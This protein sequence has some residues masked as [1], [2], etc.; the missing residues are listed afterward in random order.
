[1]KT[2]ADIIGE[3]IKCKRM[4]R[5]MTQADLARM[6]E[7]RKQANVSVW[8][9]GTFCPDAHALMQLSRVFG[10]TVDALFEGAEHADA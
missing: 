8:E 1:M 4:E 10:C 9:R 5:G 7:G 3:N 2:L 6:L